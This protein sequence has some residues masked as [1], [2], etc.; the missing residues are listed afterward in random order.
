VW[1]GGAAIALALAE[2]GDLLLRS[3]SL[4]AHAREL[5][6]SSFGYPVR[7][8]R[9]GLADPVHW[10]N[11]SWPLYRPALS[12]YFTLPLLGAALVGA[13]LALRRQTRMALVL[14][15]WI[16]VPFAAAVLLPLS[17]Y[18]R[19]IL[20]LAPPIVA[21]VAYALGA[22]V[23]WLLRR[24]PGGRGVALA[25][26]GL[27]ALLVPALVRDG[28]VLAHPAT[29]R[30]PGGD[31]TQYVTGPVAGAPWKPLVRE[32]R[33][34]AGGRHVVIA[35]DGSLFEIPQELLDYD[36]RFDFTLGV[37]GAKAARADFVLTDELPF[38]DLYAA[39]FLRQ[40]RFREVFVYPRPRGGATV[41]L[42]ER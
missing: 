10:W 1:A 18:P 24:F 20:Y 36:R 26:A 39:Q 3:S 2:C 25:A 32:L 27:V 34:R 30:Y 42:Y 17:P 41:R 9:D 16:A 23:E 40:G 7:S 29:A 21:F 38:R 22:G 12:G 13:G 15:A 19:H 14:L 8:I 37:R 28:R 5:R 31:E 11:V 6:Q 33:R 4:Y 35:T